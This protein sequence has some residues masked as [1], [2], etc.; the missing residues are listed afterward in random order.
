MSFHDLN[1]IIG[2]P[3]R[4]NALGGPA[5]RESECGV[6]EEMKFTLLQKCSS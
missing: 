5:D 4:C 2:G 3:A 6:S 1:T